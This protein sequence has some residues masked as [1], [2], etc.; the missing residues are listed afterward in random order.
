MRILHVL[1]QFSLELGDLWHNVR[2]TLNQLG[3]HGHDV[4]L[5]GADGSDTQ[6]LEKEITCQHLA[7]QSKK[8]DRELL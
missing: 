5:V 3:V 8:T 6:A 2:Q 7:F 1:P 4:L